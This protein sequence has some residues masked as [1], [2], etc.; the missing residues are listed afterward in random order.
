[1]LLEL[2]LSVEVFKTCSFITQPHFTLM[3]LDKKCFV[4][5]PWPYTRDTLAVF[6]MR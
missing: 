2:C 6:Q 5:H 3:A 4:S 1:M